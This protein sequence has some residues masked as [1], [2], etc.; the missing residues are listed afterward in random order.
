[1]FDARYEGFFNLIVRVAVYEQA[2]NCS[3][4]ANKQPVEVLLLAIVGWPNSGSCWS[5]A[6]VKPLVVT[7]TSLVIGDN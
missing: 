7:G 5:V 2:N 1:M 3:G 4:S 6:T